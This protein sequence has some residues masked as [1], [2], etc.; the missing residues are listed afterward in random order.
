MAPGR[1]LGGQPQD[2]VADLFGQG[3]PAGPGV[4]V[5]PCASDQLPVPSQ[6][7][8]RR[9]G[10][11]RPPWAGQQPRQCGQPGPFGGSVARS[12]DLA[13]QDRDLVPQHENLDV[14]ADITAGHHR[15]QLKHATQHHVQQGQGHADHPCAQTVI[16]FQP[17]IG[18]SQ[19]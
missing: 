5:G 8:R 13:A 16:K 12:F 7:R 18:S 9:H 3:G 2:Q 10:E 19:P 11:D 14:L 15:Q 1:V 4:R 17:R 6:Q